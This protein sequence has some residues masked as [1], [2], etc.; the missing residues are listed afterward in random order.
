[1]LVVLA[2]TTLR[3]ALSDVAGQV[4]E[5]RTILPYYLPLNRPSAIGDFWQNGAL[6]VCADRTFGMLVGEMPGCLLSH[7]PTPPL[8]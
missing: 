5:V 4:V 7:H 8:I 3:V 1:M 6:G 2:A